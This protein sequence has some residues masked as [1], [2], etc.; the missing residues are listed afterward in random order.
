MK[1]IVNQIT[2]CLLCHRQIK[3]KI[4][5]PA[6]KRTILLFSLLFSANIAI[7]NISLRWVSV[8]FN[9]VSMCEY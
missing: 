2:C 5:E 6:N 3:P 7:G 1:S 8:N 9:Q 4:I